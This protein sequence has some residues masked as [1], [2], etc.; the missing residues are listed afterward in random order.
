MKSA[1]TTIGTKLEKVDGRGGKA[2][3]RDG[4]GRD[5]GEG[6]SQPNVRGGKVEW[7]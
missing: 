1:R 7:V 5:E 4:K 6:K 3:G 2:R